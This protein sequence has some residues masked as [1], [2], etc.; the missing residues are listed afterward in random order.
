M[1]GHDNETNF[2]V[3][4]LLH[5][6]D[7]R[8]KGGKNPW[9]KRRKKERKKPNRNHAPPEM[10]I[11]PGKN[12]PVHREGMQVKAQEK[13]RCRKTT[14]RTEGKKKNGFLGIEPCRESG[15]GDS[16]GSRARMGPKKEYHEES[17]KDT[18]IFFET[19][20]SNFPHKGKARRESNG[21]DILLRGGRRQNP[22]AG[23]RSSTGWMA[24]EKNDWVWACRKKKNKEE[25]EKGGRKKENTQRMRQTQRLIPWN[26]KE[27]GMQPW[28][29]YIYGKR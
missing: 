20:K 24:K 16:R 15:R 4:R 26:E 6:A 23:D 12:C 9:T 14:A 25:E 27:R 10:Q 22:S 21:C 13:N 19:N 18:N 8:R 3:M 7:R 11:T 17:R 5:R 2:V 29:H 28:K 1:K